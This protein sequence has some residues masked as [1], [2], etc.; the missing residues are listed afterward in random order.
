MKRDRY[1]KISSL[2]IVAVI[3]AIIDTTQEEE[4]KK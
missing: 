2:C 1:L 3:M 4:R